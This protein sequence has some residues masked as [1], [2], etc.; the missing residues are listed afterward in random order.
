MYAKIIQYNSQ[1]LLQQKCIQIVFSKSNN[2]CTMCQ[3]L[4]CFL[5]CNFMYHFKVVLFDIVKDCFC[6]ICFSIKS[7]S[8]N[9]LC[10]IDFLGF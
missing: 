6:D 5:Y 3:C 7:S 4:F 9:L 8:S 10:A 1:I 2:S